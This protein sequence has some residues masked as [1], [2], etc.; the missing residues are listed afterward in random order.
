MTDTS[1]IELELCE[2]RPF[3][4]GENGHLA[5]TDGETVWIVIV[6][7]EA[8]MAT[9][10]PPDASLKRLARYARHYRDMAAA[11]IRRGEDYNGKVWILE[12]DVLAFP[13]AQSFERPGRRG[14]QPA[15]VADKTGIR[16]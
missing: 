11:A 10:N 12:K 14:R 1:L 3:I 7:Q 15:R 16:P 4:F 6:T 5:V 2:P 9:A 13:K 8:M